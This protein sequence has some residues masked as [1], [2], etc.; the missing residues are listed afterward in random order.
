MRVWSA[1]DKFFCSF[2]VELYEHVVMRHGMIRSIVLWIFVSVKNRNIKLLNTVHLK[3]CKLKAA[4]SWIDMET[5]VDNQAGPARS[6]PGLLPVCSFCNT[7]PHQVFSVPR[8]FWEIR[9]LFCWHQIP[10]VDL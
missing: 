6:A 10:P 8:C 7:L 1:P 5:A 9:I 4:S 3:S 2:F